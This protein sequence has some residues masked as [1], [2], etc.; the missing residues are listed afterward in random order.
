MAVE[1]QSLNYQTL[2]DDTTTA[3]TTYIWTAE[4]GRGEWEL[5]WRMAI[6][7]DTTAYTKTWR[8]AQ[9]ADWAPSDKFEFEW[10]ERATYTYWP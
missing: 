3:N 5:F 8:Y 2:I 7:D 6:V 9:D 4:I 10:D 1:V